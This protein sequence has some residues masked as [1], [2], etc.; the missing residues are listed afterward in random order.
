MSVC[1]SATREWEGVFV[2]GLKPKGVLPLQDSSNTGLTVK[3][4]PLL[5]PDLPS[6]AF[7]SNYFHHRVFDLIYPKA[8]LTGCEQNSSWVSPGRGGSPLSDAVTMCFCRV[9]PRSALHFLVDS[10]ICPNR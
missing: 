6:A 4:H 8:L 9:I 2:A 5:R 7:E 3:Y 10:Q 1:L